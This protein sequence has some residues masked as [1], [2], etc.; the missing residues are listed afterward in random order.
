MESFIEYWPLE[1]YNR[2]LIQVINCNGVWSVFRKYMYKLTNISYLTEIFPGLIV[3]CTGP[4]R[5]WQP[6]GKDRTVIIPGLI[7]SAGGVT[8]LLMLC[9]LL[10]RE[11]GG[12]REVVAVNHGEALHV[13]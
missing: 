2:G 6:P 1:R 13:S 12:R 8:C 10:V 5:A 11:G 9:D 7:S 3:D 4:S